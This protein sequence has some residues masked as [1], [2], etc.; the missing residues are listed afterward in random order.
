[1]K[2]FKAEAQLFRDLIRYTG[3][4]WEQREMPAFL[5]GVLCICLFPLIM[6]V[7]AVVITIRWILQKERG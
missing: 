1:M 5:L 4:D 3:Q 6:Y 7:R 2:V